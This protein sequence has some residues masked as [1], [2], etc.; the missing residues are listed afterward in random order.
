[1]IK[2]FI[3]SVEEI[4]GVSCSPELIIAAE[5]ASISQLINISEEYSRIIESTTLEN[6]QIQKNSGDLIPFITDGLNNYRDWLVGG[7]GF[8]PESFDNILG[9]WKIIDRL[10]HRL[11]YCHA[12]AIDGSIG[13]HIILPL[14]FILTKKDNISKLYHTKFVNF[15]NLIVSIKPLIE[16]D[17]VNIVPSNFVKFDIRGFQ[18]G[19]KWSDTDIDFTKISTKE[20]KGTPFFLPWAKYG[21]DVEEKDIM[22]VMAESNILAMANASKNFQ[23]NFDIYLPHRY[24]QNV[25][26]ILINEA[27]VK[28]NEHQSPIFLIPDLLNTE[29]PNL[30][31]ILPQDIINIR[32]SEESFYKWRYSLGSVLSKAQN[33]NFENS[34]SDNLSL[35]LLREET[36]E[37]KRDLE[38]EIRN[39]SMLNK[40]SIG[41]KKFS[42]GAIATAITYPM[43]GN[44]KSSVLTAGLTVLGELILLQKSKKPDRSLLQHYLSIH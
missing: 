12:V 21:D 40:A 29:I 33:M 13:D 8:S 36:Y 6:Y 9:V 3:L 14:K 15:L 37:A 35:Q 17:V 10:K 34:L 20:A 42:I 44:W 4:L 2:K 32:S 31:R 39:S 23:G 30:D 11:L 19:K 41:F 43:T 18:S 22:G 26:S 24:W 1:M 16:S 27:S 25:L 38:S 28:L 7:L 5:K